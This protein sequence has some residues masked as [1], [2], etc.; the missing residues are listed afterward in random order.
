[1]TRLFN[2]LFG[3]LLGGIIGAS[4]VLLLAPQS[5][6]QTRQ[7]FRSRWEEI[8]EEGRRAFA[9]RRAEL[10]ARMADIQAGRPKA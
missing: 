8:L 1:M 10:E 4:L 9:A 7:Q 6:E 5:G 3:M 2:F